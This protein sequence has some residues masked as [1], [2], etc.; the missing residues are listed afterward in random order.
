MSFDIAFMACTIKFNIASTIEGGH[1]VKGDSK[2]F[3]KFTITLKFRVTPTIALANL[4][5]NQVVQLV[6]KREHS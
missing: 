1:N 4:T 3:R 2:T 5:P 6:I